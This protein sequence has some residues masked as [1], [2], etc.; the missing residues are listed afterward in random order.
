VALDIDAPPTAPSA[1]LAGNR[2]QKHRQPQGR[3][4]MLCDRN[5][6]FHLHRL[7]VGPPGNALLGKAP[8]SAQR[9]GGRLADQRPARGPTLYGAQLHPQQPRRFS[10]GEAEPG[11]A[12][13]EFL[14]I[15][16]W[17]AFDMDYGHNQKIA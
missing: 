1:P 15:H 6:I 7:T 4:A 3:A 8:P 12:V 5:G 13:A 9:L 14:S 2:V 11:E 10:L 16:D 17:I